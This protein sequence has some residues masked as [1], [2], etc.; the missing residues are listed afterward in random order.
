MIAGTRCT[1]DIP[2]YKR[3]VGV[4]KLYRELQAE[5]SEQMHPDHVRYLIFSINVYHYNQY[6]VTRS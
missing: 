2:M 1:Y 4:W 6:L 5:H 3:L